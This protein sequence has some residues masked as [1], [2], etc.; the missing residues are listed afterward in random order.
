MVAA[1]HSFG[2]AQQMVRLQERMP[3]FNRLATKSA[4][5][6]GARDSFYLASV[7]EDGWPYIQHKGG[8]TGFLKVISETQLAYVSVAGNGQY[9]SLG[10]L[11]HSDKVAL[12]L[13]DY[14]KQR[15]LKVLGHASY[16]PLVELPEQWQHTLRV[17]L[18]R[19][20]WL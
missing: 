15:R 7:N 20:R 16:W 2:T 9:Q 18:G 12:F 14:A 4:V 17:L 5:L 8:A 11:A 6:S 3:D 13:M 1:Q 19:K 10:N